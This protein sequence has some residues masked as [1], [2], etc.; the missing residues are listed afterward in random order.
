[1]S[2]FDFFDQIWCINAASR[3]ER[4]S[5]MQAR[6]SQLAC[7]DRVRRFPAVPAPADE[8]VG[9]ALSHR[10]LIQMAAERGLR[11]VLVIEDETLFL[12][13]TEAI[14]AR[15]AGELT[16]RS[17]KILYLGT[18]RGSDG[19][20]TEPGCKHLAQAGGRTGPHAVAYGSASYAELLAVLPMSFGAMQTCLADHGSIDQIIAPIGP[21]F[22]VHPAVATVPI[23]LPF[24]APEDQEHFVP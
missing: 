1:M 9:R 19:L 17:W 4:W 7:H 2:A 11:S 3:P 14:L 5:T 24:Q 8:R 16:G 22:V 21:A 12:D 20:T 23:S 15:A 18:W 6:L 13:R 10:R